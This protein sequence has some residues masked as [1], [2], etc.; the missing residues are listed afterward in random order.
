MKLLLKT[1]F[2]CTRNLLRKLSMKI[3]TAPYASIRQVYEHVRGRNACIRIHET[4]YDNMQCIYD[5]VS[6]ND[7][8]SLNVTGATAM[9]AIFFFFPFLTYTATFLQPCEMYGC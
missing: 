2:R 7:E 5:C 3:E 8:N 1:D 4:I 9:G 6:G